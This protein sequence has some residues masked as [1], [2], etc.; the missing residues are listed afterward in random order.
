KTD[1]LNII[2]D[3]TRD[4][5]EEHDCLELEPKCD[6]LKQ[7][8]PFLLGSCHTLEK[9]CRHV[10]ESQQL[11]DLLLGEKKSLSD[12]THCRD[13][14]NDKCHH[15]SRKLYKKFE[16]SCALQNDTCEIIDFYITLHCDNLK[17]NINESN[18]VTKLSDTNGKM[19][20]L[21]KLC[22]RW[23]SYCDTLLPSCADKLAE[24]ENNTLCPGIQKY[25]K[26]YQ[27]REALENQV[28]Y[29]LRG[30][31]N[32][33]DRCST[34]LKKHC[35]TWTQNDT[36]SSL[37]KNDNTYDSNK[38]DKEVREEL[39]KRLVKKVRRWCKTL[40]KELEEAKKELEQQLNVY[41]DL[42]KEAENATKGT[43]VILTFSIKNNSTNETNNTSSH[44]LVKRSESQP[45]ITVLEAQA[46]DLV[47]I[48]V[49]EYVELKEKCEKLLLDCGFKECEGSEDTCT[50]IN[51]KCKELKPLKMRPPEVTT[52]TTTITQNVTV[53]P[54]GKTICTAG[55]PSI[56]MNCTSI[57]TT[58]TWVTH[59]STHTSTKT[60]TSTVTSK[61]TIVS[62]KKC[63][64]TQCTTDRTYPTHGSGGEEAGEV[65]PSGGMR[66]HGWG[67]KGIILIAT[68]HPSISTSLVPHNHFPNIAYLHVT[69]C[70]DTSSLNYWR[71][72]IDLGREGVQILKKRDQ[73]G[74]G[75]VIGE[76]ELLALIL[77][78]KVQEAQCR[79][80][81]EKY[82]KSLKN[83][84]LTS[85]KVHKNLKDVC[86]NGKI[87]DKEKCTR[88][89][90]KIEGKCT[91]FK[92]EL[93]K[94]VKETFTDENCE[95]HEQWCL[96]LEGA[97]SNHLTEK[98]SELRN[99]C[100]LIKR[101]NVAR[102][103]LLRA[104]KGE[105]KEKDNQCEKKL[106]E[107]CV[108]LASM[109]RE[110]LWRCLYSKETCENLVDVA[111]NKCASLEKELKKEDENVNE[112]K[113]HALLEECHFYGANCKE[114][115]IQKNCDKLRTHCEDKHNI[116]YIPPEG[117]FIPIYPRVTII[118]KVGLKG[119]Y[120][121]MTKK[122]ILIERIPFSVEDLILFLSQKEKGEFDKGKCKEVF[123]KN[124]TYLK[125]LTKDP[126]YNCDKN[127]CDS[128]E[129]KLSQ[130]R[131]T[132]KGLMK[133]NYLFNK[134]NRIT[135][136]AKIQ[137]WHELKLEYISEHCGNLESECFYL[138]AHGN[139]SQE[140]K[141][142]QNV[143]AAC[144]K[145]GV[146][147]AA[148][149]R[150]ES[151]MRG[152]FSSLTR[153]WS[154]KCQ[155][156]LVEVCK[157]LKDEDSNLLSLCLY[158]EETCDILRS[159]IEEKSSQ[160][161]NI[162]EF[163]RDYPHEEDCIRFQSKCNLLKQ[164]SSL[165][166]EP[167]HTLERNCRHLKELEE[168]QAILL[169][170]K[171]DH[172]Q[173]IDNCTAELNQ[174]CDRWSRKVHK[175]FGLSCALQEDSCERM[176]F[177]IY[178]YCEN[179]KGNIKNFNIVNTLKEA[180][181]NMDQLRENCP[182]WAPY[183]NQLLST[184]PETNQEYLN[185]SLCQEIQ[186]YCKPYQEKQTLEDA[187]LYKF[188]GS[189]KDES[190][191]NS[192]LEKHC[193]TWNQNDTFGSLCNDT[194]NS[195]K[196]DKVKE[197]CQRLVDRVKKLCKKL[198]DKLKEENEELTRRIKVY[199]DLKQEAEGKAN[200][201]NVILTF[202][203]KNDTTNKT[204][205]PSH[206][207]V[208]RSE[209]QPP[210]T[211]LEAEAFDL[212]AMTVDL[213]VDLKEKC[214]KL[215][216]DC[217]FKECQSSQDTCNEINDKCGALKPLEMK[218][219]QTITN[220]ETSTL[221][222]TEKVIVDSEGKTICTPGAPLINMN[223]TSI[224]TTDTWVTHTSTHT[225]TMTKTS[226]VTSKV[227]IISTKKCQP[228]QCTTDRT[229]PTH[230]SGGEEAGE[231]KPSGGIRRWI[232]ID[233]GREG[234]QMLKKRDQ[235]A[236]GE[237]MEE[238]YL[239]ALILKE[240]TEK[241]NCKN[242][243]GK[244]CKALHDAGLKVENVDIKLKDVCKE[245][246]ANEDT[247]EQLETKVQEKC[248]EFK[249]ELEKAPKEKPIKNEN[250]IKYE[251]QCLFLEGA[252]SEDVIKKCSELRNE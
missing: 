72:D 140:S 131:N 237:E 73:G 58:D 89:K 189:L 230:S 113:C 95:K 141:A 31:L 163:T 85:E 206:A 13:K 55:T 196:N 149:E 107:H 252:C 15:Y 154:K 83:A 187:L 152:E 178:R 22:P 222:V 123:E 64:P 39:C 250:C 33:T 198:P 248:T 235:E 242:K 102:E 50:K 109:S 52:S 229:H 205:T 36:F 170:E 197:L 167:C 183:C 224:H 94:A 35:A 161:R 4:S 177:N 115:D 48:V 98:C 11:K 124:C 240:N 162:L 99:Q 175:Q 171:K 106:E 88:L 245:K 239:L 138:E 70:V 96:F 51:E 234:V 78:E 221:T 137:S 120:Q 6:K 32:D 93:E 217:G 202:S 9:N 27:K 247:C 209:S 238:E 135:E 139:T 46:F 108:Y 211:I 60:Q 71:V 44:A 38:T 43:N 180:N 91:K 1:Q 148:Y 53:D 166:S 129:G 41:D 213:Y 225:S 63:Q 7:D 42:K 173:T 132:L 40:P 61:V 218:Q 160:L 156:K 219:P 210:I 143:F 62:T 80:K 147:A 12:I 226:T 104:L 188:Q 249:D 19:D 26:P 232:D 159:D 192:T 220:T 179:L 215:L 59:T 212:V 203:I 3:I 151:Q 23:I 195:S 57:H 186:T 79:N 117:P 37:C 14:V 82:C 111:K 24:E 190:E 49:N 47:A 243:L 121:E 110:L 208:K 18:I 21:R 118:E 74:K 92:D 90:D 69:K 127:K 233:L 103:I 223:C 56:N 144:Y 146:D 86:E 145:R 10:R 105:L 76:E 29:E 251:L 169:D 101:M 157:K 68:V 134:E 75:E 150:L 66:I 97:C 65:K 116:V 227:T 182:I 8:H 28:I 184:C 165:L 236:K 112:D 214:R 122:G 81:L 174:Q 114:D 100:Y 20:E 54:Q 17:K 128:L 168:I 244:Y 77:K 201:T 67:A 45:P 194:S 5:P 199:N 216:L 185:I 181:S 136:N 241:N 119:L 193:T 30:S 130:R 158:P 172:F 207:L 191:C 133:Q 25:C 176:T 125:T 164:D 246:K 142:C 84:E 2:L 87:K 16:L 155:E 231:V 126:I 228:T 34:T 153:D 204:D 200:K